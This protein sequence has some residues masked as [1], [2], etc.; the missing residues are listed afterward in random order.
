MVLDK[1]SEASTYYS[2]HPKFKIAFEYIFSH[3][4]KSI[5]GGSKIVVVREYIL[6]SNFE[7]WMKRIVF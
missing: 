5:P 2:L 1:L 4:F 6:K 3:D 7:F